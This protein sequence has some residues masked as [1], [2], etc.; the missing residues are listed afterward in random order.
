MR[1]S[2]QE[3][4]GGAGISEA[5]S[6][7][8]RIGWGPVRN[9]EHDLGTDLFVRARD[10]RR[11]DRGGI[12]G[13]QVKA[14]ATWFSAPVRDHT[15]SLIG[16][17]YYEPNADHFDDWVTHGLPHLLVLH[18]LEDR[19]SYWVHVTAQ[20]V[21][22]TGKGCKI[23]VKAVQRMLGHAKASMILDTYADL[24]D[25][26]LEALADR[27]DTLARRGFERSD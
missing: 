1:A 8:E 7:F 5:C 13:V 2:P 25:D 26:Y 15:G 12:V 23:V 17:V 9:T 27:L 4:T 20:A 18:D 10:D 22:S 11:F 24:F 19:T 14:G 21:E 6:N 3:Q 16:W